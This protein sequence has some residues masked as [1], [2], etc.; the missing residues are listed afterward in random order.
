MFMLVTM[1]P[2]ETG[3]VEYGLRASSY[4]TGQAPSFGRRRLVRKR[5]Y[6]DMTCRDLTLGPITGPL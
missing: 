3:P 2:L 6:P 5:R 1:P 4:F